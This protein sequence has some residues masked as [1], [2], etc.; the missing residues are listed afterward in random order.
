MR[1]GEEKSGNAEIGKSGNA[2]K[3]KLGNAERGRKEGKL[4]ASVFWAETYRGHLV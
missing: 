3:L 1:T 2:E 4:S